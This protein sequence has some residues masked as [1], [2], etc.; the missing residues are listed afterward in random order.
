[1]TRIS[2][3]VDS[4]SKGRSIGG[5]VL[6]TRSTVVHLPLLFD[7]FFRRTLLMN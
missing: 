3:V 7:V 5:D 1:M 6:L 4:T 2:L